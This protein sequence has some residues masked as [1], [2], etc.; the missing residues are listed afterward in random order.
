MEAYRACKA[1]LEGAPPL[2]L[3]PPEKDR[4][5]ARFAQQLAASYDASGAAG[6]L[7]PSEKEEMA[8]QELVHQYL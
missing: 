8:V 2:R 4:Y 6:D 1:L 3:T 7:D 5:C